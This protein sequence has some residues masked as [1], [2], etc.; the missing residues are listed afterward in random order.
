MISR[1]V[2]DGEGNLHVAFVARQPAEHGFLVHLSLGREG[3]KATELGGVFV[4]SAELRRRGATIVPAPGGTYP[5]IA[6][7]SGRRIYMAFTSPVRVVSG[8]RSLDVNSIWV[9]R[10]DDGGR[11]WREPVLAHRAGSRGAYE[12]KIVAM[13]RDSV[14]LVWLKALGRAPWGEEVWHSVSTDGGMTWGSPSRVRPPEAHP[15][16]NLRAVAMPSGGLYAMF[17]HQPAPLP[18]SRKPGA[19]DE[20]LFYARWTRSGWTEPRPLRP[21]RGV[22]QFDAG[23]DAGGRLHLLWPTEAAER[24]GPPML[25]YAVGTPCG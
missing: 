17:T 22:F 13:G 14:H 6:A 9:R 5:S 1:L 10:S 23:F 18:G 21:E 11:S 2:E 16:R 12:P 4:P 3:W 15:V 24:E 8:P 25:H 19:T 7:G 20:Q